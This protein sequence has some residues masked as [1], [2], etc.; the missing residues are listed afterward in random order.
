MRHWAQADRQGMGERLAQQLARKARTVK[1]ATPYELKTKL[2]RYGLSLG[3]RL[4][5]GT[6]YGLVPRQRYGLM[7]RILTLF[8]LLIPWAEAPAQR[9]DPDDYIYPILQ[10]SRLYSANF[11]E[12]RPGHFPCRSGHQDRRRS[13]SSARRRGRRLCL[14]SLGLG[15]RLRSRHLPHAA[16]RHDGRLRPPATFPRRHRGTCPHGALCPPLERRQ[17]LV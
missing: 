2:I 15:R 10:E 16:Q 4:R 8:L 5:G 7:R 13:G 12:L 14:A 17:P 3:I 9:L 1:Y 11:G 6:G